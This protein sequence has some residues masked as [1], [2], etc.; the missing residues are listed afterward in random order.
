MNNILHWLLEENNPSIRYFTLKDLLNKKESSFELIK[1]K[2][3]ILNSKIISKIFAG[4]NTKGYWL[5]P[6]SPYLP[7]YKSTYWTIMLLGYLGIDRIDKR[8]QRACEYILKFQHEQGGFMSETR[9]TL[10]RQYEWHLKRKKK[11]PEFNEWVNKMLHDSQSSCLTGNISAALIRLG[12]QNDPRVKKTLYWLTKIQ[13]QDGGW[14][15]PYW[16]AH[17][18]DTHGC[19]DGTICS[20]EAFSEVPQENRT[21]E[22]E[23]TIKRGAEFLLMHNLYKVD[24]HGYKTINKKWFLLSYPWFYTYSILRGL[25]VLTK[26]GYTNDKRLNDAVEVLLA[27]RKKEGC[28]TLENTPTSR[29]QANIETKGKPS[30]WI[31]L[32]ALRVLKRLNRF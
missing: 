14:L 8:V 7:K 19:F 28:W 4:Q 23:R 20:L 26:L 24:H 1:L 11:L 18:K 27:K 3:Q 31:T 29:M 10:L 6:N 13:N 9:Q 12:Y 25:D 15:C 32:I 22:M 5:N 21:E 16:S 30:K 17:I 2:S